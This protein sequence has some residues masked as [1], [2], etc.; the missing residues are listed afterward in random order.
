MTRRRFQVHFRRTKSCV[1]R[2]LGFRQYSFHRIARVPQ[3]P[4]PHTW[5]RPLLHWHAIFPDIPFGLRL[6]IR[7]RNAP[8]N[9]SQLGWGYGN[10]PRGAGS[11]FLVATLITWY[12][13]AN[14]AVTWE[15]MY[16]NWASRSGCWAPSSILRVPCKL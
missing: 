12:P 2:G 8:P 3:R 7:P 6:A 15:W 4:A 5:T 1:F 16:R 11:F 9:S 14:A 10:A 13:A